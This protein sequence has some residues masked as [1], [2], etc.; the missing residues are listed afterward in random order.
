[1]KK[2]ISNSAAEAIK[3]KHSE[4]EI[5]NGILKL[6]K[7]EDRE[8]LVELLEHKLLEEVREVLYADGDDHRKSEL[9]DIIEVAESLKNGGKGS[10]SEGWILTESKGH[11]K[12]E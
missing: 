6:G 8:E 11:Y 10:F 1:M 4:D 2:L 3:E 12:G 9:Q 5:A 7:V